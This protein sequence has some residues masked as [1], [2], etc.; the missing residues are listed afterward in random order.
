[1][2]RAG[3][4]SLSAIFT[5]SQLNRLAFQ[6]LLAA[7]VSAQLI[8]LFGRDSFNTGAYRR[9]CR[10]FLAGFPGHYF[11]PEAAKRICRYF[12]ENKLLHAVVGAVDDI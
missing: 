7:V 6:W 5:A 3:L 2:K 1:M 11:H 9:H 12:P 4:P 10:L 8:V